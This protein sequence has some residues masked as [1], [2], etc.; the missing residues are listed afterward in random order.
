[1]DEERRLVRSAGVM[2]FMTLLSRVFGYVRDNLQAQVLGASRSA[3]AFIIAFRIPNLL[4]RLVG[5]GA[6]TAAFVPTLSDY[7]K[8]ENRKEMWRFAAITFWTM[9]CVLMVLTALGV[10]FS[11]TLVK[12]MAYGFSGIEGKWDLTVS[13]NR[14]MFPYLLFIGLAALVQGI[15]NVNGSFAVPAFTPVL[16]NLSIIGAALGLSPWMKEPAYAF[17]WGVLFGGLLQIAFQIPFVMKMGMRFPLMTGFR[18]PGVRQIGRLMLPGLFG[19]GITQIMLLVD[20]F[21]ASLLKEGSVSA[22][23]YSGRVN[24]LALGS[25]AISVSTVILPTLS[26]QAAAGRIDEMRRTLLYGLRV[27]AFITLPASVGLILFRDRIIGVLFQHG[28]FTAEDTAYTAHALMFYAV[29]LLPFGAVKILAPAFY[30][31][32]DTRTPAILAAWTLGAHL[33]FCASLSYLMKQGGIALADSLSATLN[34]SLLMGVFARRHGLP[35]VKGLAIPALR[36]LGASVLMGG[37]AVVVLRCLDAAL[38]G[39]PL[40]RG[41]ALFGTLGVATA[42]YFLICR[43]M[44]VKEMHDVLSAMPLRRS[45]RK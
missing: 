7:M 20:S 41:L 25:F 14:L 29:G 4:R 23:Y 30:S 19:M 31:Q 24:E 18:D 35:W 22:L 15:L 11:P 33:C 43:L 17:A 45:S 36:L 3:D 12:L 10:I 2:S 6:F 38:A 34:M 16:L 28:R 39:V 5:E 26:K 21:F 8:P 9:A 37:V 42:T 32:K 1:M 44:G 40:G 27:V 13:L